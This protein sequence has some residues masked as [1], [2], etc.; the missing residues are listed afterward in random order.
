[1][2]V[3]RLVVFLILNL[4]P[5]IQDFPDITHLYPSFISSMATQLTQV[6]E[7][8]ARANE[9]LS[10]LPSKNKPVEDVATLWREAYANSRQIMND[11][12]GEA[13]TADAEHEH[14]SLSAVYRE[15]RL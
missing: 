11:E 1:M 3:D 4:Y 14:S 7:Q 10:W 5:L 15:N 6:V 12:G 2:E 13:T 9:N 8:M